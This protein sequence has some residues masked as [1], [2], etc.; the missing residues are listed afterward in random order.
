MQNHY[1]TLL[2]I[3]LPLI[4]GIIGYFINYFFER[5]KELYSKV[6]Q[7]RREIYQNFVNLIISFSNENSK[8][9]SNSI[10]N[11]LNNFYKKYVLFASPNV[12]ISLTYFI[13]LINLNDRSEIEK[14]Y[15]EALTEIIYEM[16]KDLGLSNNN[17]G[18][19]GGKLLNAI[20][21]KK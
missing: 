2:T 14:K 9:E 3:I 6:N 17:L 21:I 13:E 4:G 11:E 10:K 20:V 8:L 7:E 15:Y 16:R 18:K 5:K 12:I 19:K 1:I